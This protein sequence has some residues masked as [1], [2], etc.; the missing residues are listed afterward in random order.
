MRHRFFSF[1]IPAHNEELIIGETLRCLEALEYPKE[2]YEVIVVENGST[3]ATYEKAK[4]HESANLKVYRALEKGVSRTR[5]FGFAKCSPEFEWC[6]FMDADV[7]V[8]SGFLSE[9][10]AYLEAH[11]KAGYGT[12][13]VTLDSN[14]FAARFWSRANNF[15]YQLFKVLFTTHIVRKDF[16]SQISY[17]EDLTSGEDIEYGRMLSKRARF[18]FMKTGKVRTSDRRFRK[19]GYTKMFFVNLYRGLSIFILPKKVLKKADWEVIR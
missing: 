1:V 18:F 12:A 14:S 15:F 4:Q 8:Q 6:I 16:A 2:R 13:T 5:N 7:S 9:L 10:N 19:N 3:D 11:P 17:D